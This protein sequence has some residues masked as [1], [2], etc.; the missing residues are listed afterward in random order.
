MH[1]DRSIVD[2]SI[3]H[4]SWWVCECPTNNEKRQNESQLYSIKRYTGG[5]SPRF[6]S[7]Y[8]TIKAVNPSPPAPYFAFL[9]TGLHNLALAPR[10]GRSLSVSG[11][12]G[13][14]ECPGVYSR[15]D[16]APAPQL[17]ATKR[18]GFRSAALGSQTLLVGRLPRSAASSSGRGDG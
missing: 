11:S 18:L 8:L 9:N 7:L 3:A 4:V 1:C 5:F 16:R 12:S 6:K 2:S 15:S 13:T 10:E 17:G 14:P